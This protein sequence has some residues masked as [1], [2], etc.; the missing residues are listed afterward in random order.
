MLILQK[1]DRV[2]WNRIITDLERNKVCCYK[3]SKRSGIPRTTLLGWKNHGNRPKLEDGL[4]VI[5]IWCQVFDKEFDEIP[6]FDFY[7][8]Y[9]IKPGI[10]PAN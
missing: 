5:N 2:D 6:V 3:L 8:P 4:P 10:S 7:E 1:N 9:K